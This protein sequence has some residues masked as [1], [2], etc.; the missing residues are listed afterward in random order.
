MQKNV[1]TRVGVGRVKKSGNKMT[2]GIDFLETMC[3]TL[4]V[5]GFYAYNI[6]TIGVR[7]IAV[8]E[9]YL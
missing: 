3:Y 1:K 9:I 7:Y 4:C 2:L 6:L 8:V 5:R